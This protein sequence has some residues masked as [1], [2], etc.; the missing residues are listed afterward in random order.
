[1]R[2]NDQGGV[3]IEVGACYRRGNKYYLGIDQ[4]TLLTFKDG[5]AKLVTPRSHYSKAPVLT[6]VNDLMATWNVSMK[7]IDEVSKKY[8]RIDKPCS[9]RPRVRTPKGWRYERS[10]N[11]Y[12]CD[13]A[14]ARG[15]RYNE[16]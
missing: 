14:P 5:E 11:Y 12:K 3:M 7:E 1:M 6:S 15:F 8:F 13:F 10:E 2:K 9:A 4:F 16:M